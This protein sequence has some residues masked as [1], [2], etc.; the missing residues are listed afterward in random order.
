MKTCERRNR[1]ESSKQKKQTLGSV[2][3]FKFV[4]VTG[5]QNLATGTSIGSVTG[6]LNL[7]TDSFESKVQNIYASSFNQFS[8]FGNSTLLVALLC[9]I[10]TKVS[11]TFHV[12]HE[13]S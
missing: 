13:A 6:P 1:V 5:S 4:S 10:C 8:K 12:S 11:K 3:S 7:V 2:V 9:L